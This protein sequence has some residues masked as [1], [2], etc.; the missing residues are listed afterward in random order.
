METTRYS[1]LE[2]DVYPASGGPPYTGYLAGDVVVWTGA[3]GVRHE[4]VLTRA[5]LS[6]LG[7]SGKVRQFRAPYLN[8]AHPAN[9]DPSPSAF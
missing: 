3:Y 1:L 5:E 4:E 2:I 8:W 7:A 9:R 6:E